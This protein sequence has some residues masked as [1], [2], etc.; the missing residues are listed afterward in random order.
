VPSEHGFDYHGARHDP[1]HSD[2][3]SGDGWRRLDDKPDDPHYGEPLG[4]HWDSADYPTPNP[5]NEKTFDLVEHPEEPYGHDSDGRPLTKDEYDK[6]YNKVGPNGEEWENYP[7]NDGAV[8]GTRV[9]YDS[10][11]AYLRDYGPHLDRIGGDS[12]EY[13][14]VVPDRVPPAFE[15]RGLPISSLN[16]PY[17]EF[18]L[19]ALP[20]GWTIEISKIAPAFGR[21]GG[22]LQVLICD[23][24]GRKVSVEQ[25]LENGVLR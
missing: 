16:S 15:D 17:K 5:V 24:L 11:K 1:V 20:G 13:L 12:G 9:V 23:E 6:R 7:P 2:E 8:A 3:P 10:G 22:A 21:D 19:E 14:G 4:R 18:S 25:L